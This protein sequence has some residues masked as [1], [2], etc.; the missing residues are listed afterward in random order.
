[1]IKIENTSIYGFEAA[2]HIMGS[3]MDSLDKCDS[4][5]N[6]YYETWQIGES[7]L[8][9]MSKLAHSESDNSDFGRFIIV[10]TD[11]TAPLYWWQELNICK[12]D[13]THNLLDEPFDMSDFS[14]EKIPNSV[15]GRFID[16]TLEALNQCRDVYLNFD[17]Y[18][19]TGHL[20][21]NVKTKKDIWYMLIC[22]LPLSYNQKHTMQ[23]DYHMLSRIY[24]E[25][26]NNKLDEWNEFCA[27]IEKLP[28]FRDIYC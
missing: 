21:E 4:S 6:H 1:M 17:E 18:K 27:W 16:D 22:L 3:Q 11:I 13:T 14:W 25:R 28:Y 5:F 26:K 19:E 7:D 10:I 8:T 15:G 24:R 23:F 20:D 2:T 9:L 12:A